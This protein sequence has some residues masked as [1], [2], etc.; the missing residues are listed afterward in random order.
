MFMARCDADAD[1][2]EEIEIVSSFECK[3]I[4]NP[5]GSF[6]FSVLGE[7]NTYKREIK[8][9]RLKWETRFRNIKTYTACLRPGFDT[10][11]VIISFLRLWYFNY[12]FEV[13]LKK[14]ESVV[15]SSQRENDSFRKI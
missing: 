4:F 5:S 9:E 3:Y 13:F 15:T 7:S 1:W 10:A 12:I 14:K 8:E 6:F 2:V 11:P